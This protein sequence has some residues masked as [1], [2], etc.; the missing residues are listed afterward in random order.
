[1]VTAYRSTDQLINLLPHME[2]REET[3]AVLSTNQKMMCFIKF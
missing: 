1:M 3:K 2:S